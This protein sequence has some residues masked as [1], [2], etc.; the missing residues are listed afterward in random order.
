MFISI[1]YCNQVKKGT[2]KEN[3]KTG[4][5]AYLVLYY[6]APKRVRHFHYTQFAL[7]YQALSGVIIGGRNK[8]I[9]F[10]MPPTSK[11]FGMHIGLGLSVR[12]SVRLCV[13]LALG[14]EPLEIGS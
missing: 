8:Y 6:I 1:I 11:K 10:V 2:C 13:T 9:I 5:L 12:L 4:L 7:G 3:V 14:Q